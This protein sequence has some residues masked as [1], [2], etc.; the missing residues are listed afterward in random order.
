MRIAG[1]E[2][3]PDLLD[4][5]KAQPQSLSRRRLASELCSR[6]AW[7]SASGR[8][9]LMGARK[10]LSQLCRAGHLPPPSHPTPP[11][12][13]P[14]SQPSHPAEPIDCSLD[15]LLPLQIQLVP[16]AGSALSN[17][18][19]RLLDHH[20]PL[21][22][23]PLC[24]AQLRYLVRCSN[25]RTVAALSFSAAAR[26]LHARD[27]WIGWSPH[28][29]VLNRH[30]VVNNSRFLIPS[31]VHVPNLASHLLSRISDRLRDDWFTRYGYRPVLLETF[32][33]SS[34]FEGTSYAAANWICLGLTRG[35]GRQDR[36]RRIALSP[37][38]VWLL[39]LVRDP[40]PLLKAA[41]PAACAPAPS[42]SPS[43]WAENELGRAQLHDERLVRRGCEL[44]RQFFS[45]PTAQIPQAC[46]SRSRTRAAYRFMDNEQVN[47][48]SLLSSHYLATAERAAREQV[49][50]AVQDTTSFNYTSLEDTDELGPIG[51]KAQGAMGLLLHSTLAF[52]TQGTPL[53]LVHA[54]SWARDPE[55]TGRK[56]RRL[57][58]PFEQKESAR[59]MRSLQALEAHQARCPGVRWVSVGDREADIYELFVWARE[60]E[61]R[62]DLLVRAGQPRRLEGQEGLWEHME[63][64]PVAAELELTVPRKP[65]QKARIARMA[66]RFGPVDLRPPKHKPRLGGVRMWGVL[67][68]EIDP[69]ADKQGLEWM[70]LTTLA[71]QTA[72]QAIEKL[73]WYG[74]RWG[75][76]SFHRVLKS[77]CR[78]EN[79][80][81]GHAR[82]LENCI[83]FD[84][85]VAW[86]IFALTKLGRE[87]PDVPCTEHF[88]EAQWKAVYLYTTPG[89][90]KKLPEKPPSLREM[91]RRVAAL[92]G[93]LGRKGDGEPG[94]QTLWLGLERM[95]DLAAMFRIMDAPQP[96]VSSGSDY[97]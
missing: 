88:E 36:D 63:A 34:R 21:R 85:V 18:W 53:G 64:L 9:S 72:E 54:Q 97:G 2:I 77:G 76:E 29:R 22:S 59:W 8:P 4:W 52:N 92:G 7:T 20:H 31:F 93:F 47:F 86:R 83:A 55:D 67:C 84:M 10:V 25:G 78:L 90:P 57:K 24:G 15:Q 82:R 23:G 3:T 26:H 16:K 42:F 80:Q 44:L 39:P 19:N 87:R 5:I 6:A 12:R 96:A 69:P 45:R 62:P 33:D 68:R 95:D 43:D 91:V 73:K 60:T 38:T 14:P 13:K 27:A 11:P 30:L 37:K 61:G 49:V 70:L 89:R 48:Q 50:L 94:T 40:K 17:E 75:I 35:R 46:G 41:P 51:A 58:E 79:R 81:L 71:V 66:V 1:R 28:A 56:H 32:V 65:G 74:L